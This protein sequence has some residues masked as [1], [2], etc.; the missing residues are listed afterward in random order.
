MGTATSN[1]HGAREWISKEEAAELLSVK[2]RQVEKRAAEGYLEKR[3]LPRQP[4]EK[5]AR[6][7]YKRAD[8]DA[9]LD[10]KPNQYGKPMR[11]EMPEA[12]SGDGTADLARFRAAAPPMPILPDPGSIIHFLAT[13]ARV[14]PPPRREPRAWLTLAEAVEYCG[15][16]AA[17]LERLLREGLVYSFGRGP[18]TWR[19]QRAALDA[20]GQAAHQ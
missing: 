1:G 10:G 20:Y 17:E 5:Q 2:P 8:V 19:I 12:P 7:E 16:P 15:L 6:V 4:H 9:I 11:P 14:L 13:L 18:K 3:T